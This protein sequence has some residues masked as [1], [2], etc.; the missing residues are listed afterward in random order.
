MQFPVLFHVAQLERLKKGPSLSL[1]SSPLTH[2]A[3]VMSTRTTAG[4][5][6]LQQGNSFQLMS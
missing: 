3:P 4:V 6:D 1:M 5:S 2:E